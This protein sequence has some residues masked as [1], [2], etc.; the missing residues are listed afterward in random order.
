[1]RING[2]DIIPAYLTVPLIVVM[3]M[4]CSRVPS[5]VI[6][7]GDMAELLADLH[8]GEGVVESERQS[9]ATDSMRMLLR[10]SIYRRHDVTRQQ[11]DSSMMW[12]GKNIEKYMEVYDEV[13]E[14]LDKRLADANS[15]TSRPAQN[16][17]VYQS[18]SL[19]GDSIDVWTQLHYRRFYDSGGNN[20]VTYRMNKDRNWQPGDSYTLNFKAINT[21]KPVDVAMLVEYTDGTSDY[22]HRQFP[23]SGWNDLK[24]THTPDK[25]ASTMSVVISYEPARK[26][27]AYI[28]S[29]SLIRRHSRN[30]VRRPVEADVADTVEHRN[31][32][33]SND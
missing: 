17:S 14:I 25:E 8:E 5:G 12:Y 9:F 33:N 16:G 30:T 2:R 19:E 29:I 22:S 32:G 24:I 13:I 27:V 10:E 18:V 15:N 26:E 7:P 23:H 21:R 28:D 31:N 1:M 4:A 6:P 11:V 3:V 20:F